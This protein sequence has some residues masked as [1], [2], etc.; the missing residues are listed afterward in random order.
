MAAEPAYDTHTPQMHRS[1]CRTPIRQSRQSNGNHVGCRPSIIYTRH[2]AGIGRHR[3]V[4]LSRLPRIIA[5]VSSDRAPVAGNWGCAHASI[6]T[7]L[8]PT[9][10]RCQQQHELATNTSQP[11]TGTDG[12]ITKSSRYL[13]HGKGILRTRTNRCRCRDALGTYRN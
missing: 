10:D 2:G 6:A 4:S 11:T 8:P 13:G 1:D 7:G 5:S 12:S 3:K 9:S